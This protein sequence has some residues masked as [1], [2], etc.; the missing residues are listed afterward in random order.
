M[1]EIF[2]KKVWENRESAH[3]NRYRL[4]RIGT[5]DEYDVIKLTPEEEGVVIEGTP[6]KAETFN[7]LEERL[8]ESFNSINKE[9]ENDKSFIIVTLPASWQAG[10]D[11]IFYQT[12]E[13]NGILEDN[14]YMISIYEQDVS[15]IENSKE[16]NYILKASYIDNSITFYCRIPTTKEL[17][18]ICKVI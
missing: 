1:G 18:L 3:P 8:E 2:E 9:F 4:T 14:L 11:G 5:S 15:S 12:I 6:L 7:N 10:S 13:A 17:K 16:F